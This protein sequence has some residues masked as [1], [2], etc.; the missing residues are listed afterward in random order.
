MAEEASPGMRD[1]VAADAPDAPA[2]AEAERGVRRV[3]VVDDNEANRYVVSYWL[4]EAGFAVVEAGTGD[5]ALMEVRRAGG[6]PD[7]VLLDIRLP[8]T[9]GFDVLRHLRTDPDTAAIPVVHLSASFTTGEWR[10][11]GLEAGAEAYLTHP[12]EPRELIATVRSLLRLRAAES[13]RQL[14]LESERVARRE[15]DVARVAAERAAAIKADFLAT[16]SHEF[17]TPLNAFTGYL[18][19][20]EMELAGPLTP[21]QRDYVE[22]LKASSEH[23]SALVNDVLDLAKLEANRMSVAREH[24]RTTTVVDAAISLAK[25]QAHARGVRLENHSAG[26]G[27]AYVGDEYR[28]RQI[29]LNLLSNA[30]KFTEPGGTVSV[31]TARMPGPDAGWTVLRVADTGIGIP[32]EQQAA[33]FEPFVQV[34]GGADGPYRRTKG[35]T[36]LGLSISRRFARLMGGDLTVES[37]LGRGSVFTLRLPATDI[38]TMP[39]PTSVVAVHA[40][41]MPGALPED[42]P[43]LLLPMMS[44][45]GDALRSEMNLLLDGLVSRLRDDAALPPGTAM[46]DRR[47]LT[48]H[49]PTL[50]A[51]IAQTLHTLDDP[52]GVPSATA[53]RDH[54]QIQRT[55]AELHGRQRER[56]GWGAADLA[57]ELA[58]LEALLT[59]FVDREFHDAPTVRESVTTLLHQFIEQAGRVATQALRRAHDAED[60]PHP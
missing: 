34:E 47:R 29:L 42:A 12:V 22:R 3:L 56:I 31:S 54:D 7:L 11:H 60:Q 24:A 59:G 39:T 52:A 26:G 6:R 4:R 45:A 43:R 10:A 36:G 20:L 35:G 14:L 58:H 51:A 46:L 50:L 25:P 53:L 5:E 23:L 48:G 30:V 1:H 49:V 40:G 57:R 13:E 27:D 55:I 18:Q 15:A 33:I 8:D 28:V 41:E 19:L 32:R 37:M 16:M 44:V 2:A 17:R 9:S 21:Q 38:A